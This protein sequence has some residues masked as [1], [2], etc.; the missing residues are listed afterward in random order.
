MIYVC[1]TFL[2]NNHHNEVIVT[3]L[4]EIIDLIY[5]ICSLKLKLTNVVFCIAI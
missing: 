1:N 3:A 5:T 2:Y 4:L